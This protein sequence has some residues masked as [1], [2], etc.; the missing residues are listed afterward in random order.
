MRLPQSV[1]QITDLHLL[2]HTG[3]RLLG[4]D[5][6]AS[7]R[8]V[9]ATALAER[10]P[11]AMLV[12]GDIAHEPSA[13]TYRRCR[14]LLDEHFQGPLLCLPGNHDCLAPM[15]AAGLPMQPLHLPGWWL[16]GWDTHED[17]RG[18][19]R[20]APDA[21][22]ALNAWVEAA[23][24]CGLIATHHPLVEVGCPW[25]DKDR[26]SNAEE[27]LE[28]LG[29]MV[30]V[31]AVVFGH[32]HQV[33]DQQRRNLHLLGAPSTCF[34]FKPGSASFAVD[35]TAPG[36]RWLHLFADGRLDTKVG[37]VDGFPLNLD[38]SQRQ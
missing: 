19:A 2:E 8:A 37:R 13:S 23:T 7:L 25:L 6:T 31:K 14:Q 30:S 32:A 18:G 26:L 36:Y 10:E 34:Q 28:C 29:N 1:L 12:T 5:T 11:A 9:L 4:V 38:L 17:E 21:W 35:D 22:D 20:F 33:V 16:A 3:D 15:A 24:P 27:L